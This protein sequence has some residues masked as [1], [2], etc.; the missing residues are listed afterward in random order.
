MLASTHTHVHMDIH[1]HV[2]MHMHMHIHMSMHMHCA[3]TQVLGFQQGFR[4]CYRVFIRV[5]LSIYLSICLSIAYLYTNLSPHLSIEL[6]VYVSVCLSTPTPKPQT[7]QPQNRNPKLNHKCETHK[8]QSQSRRQ[9][10]RQKMGGAEQ[11]LTQQDTCYSYHFLR[12]LNLRPTLPT[13]E[14]KERELS[15]S[16]YELLVR[17]L[18]VPTIMVL[19]IPLLLDLLSLMIFE[20]DLKPLSSPILWPRKVQTE[21]IR[22]VTNLLD[23]LKLG[24]ILLFFA[25]LE[26]FGVFDSTPQSQTPEP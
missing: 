11:P 4:R 14:V 23:N 5:Y 19:L 25:S 6:F 22:K 8:I 21:V 15:K 16:V 10:N 7:S 9:R 24:L 12:H 18:L 2:G 17:R 26:C 3:H 1:T 20:V 13:P